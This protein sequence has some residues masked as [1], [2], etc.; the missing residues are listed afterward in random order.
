MDI[1]M[2]MLSSHQEYK[3]MGHIADIT[4]VISLMPG[5]VVKSLQLI[6]GYPAKRVLSAMRKHAR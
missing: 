5:P 1:K 3:P 4:E 6:W 2:T